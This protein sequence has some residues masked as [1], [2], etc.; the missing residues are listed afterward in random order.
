MSQPGPPGPQPGPPETP[1]Q[2][3]WQN[4]HGIVLTILWCLCADALLIIVRYYKNWYK[5]LLLHSLF[6]VINILTII[7]VTLVVV[8]DRNYLFNA[9]GFG[10]MTTATKVHFIFG[11]C[12]VLMIVIIQVI[13]FLIKREIEGSTQPP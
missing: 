9:T 5:Y 2:G 12:F 4:V 1:I 3:F 8:L 10:Q 13:G 11:L 7:M 6:G